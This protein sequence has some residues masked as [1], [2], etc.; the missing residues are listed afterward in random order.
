MSLTHVDMY[1]EAQLGEDTTQ[2]DFWDAEAKVNAMTGNFS[3]LERNWGNFLT[4]TPEG[5]PVF[6]AGVMYDM[7]QK[8]PPIP[9]KLA[10]F[11][12]DQQPVQMELT[13]GPLGPM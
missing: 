2:N 9:A 1:Q 7:G 5:T 10:E 3:W 12:K 13:L 6:V 8:P 4:F 11:F